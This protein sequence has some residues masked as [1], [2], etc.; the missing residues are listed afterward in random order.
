MC[1]DRFGCRNDLFLCGIQ[2]SVGNILTDCS[3]EQEIILRHNAHL[4]AETFDADSLNIVP[5]NTD[6]S[7]LYIVEPADEIDNGCF[8]GTRRSYQ[9]YCLTGLD[10]KADIIQDFSCIIIGEAY[11]GEVYTALDRRHFNNVF[12]IG[13]TGFGIQYLKDTFCTGYI[14]NQ[15]VIEVTE[16]H[17]RLP[18]HRNISTKGN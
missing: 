12:R 13:N 8:T 1:M 14:G 3:G 15:L 10:M 2:L 16:V 4:A 7:T 11:V 5:V 9:C 6:N 17:D 18:E